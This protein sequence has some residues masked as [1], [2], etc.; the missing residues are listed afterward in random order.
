[1]GQRGDR[2]REILVLV[3]VRATKKMTPAEIRR[4][5]KTLI[6]TQSFYMADE[7]QIRAIAVTS[8]GRTKD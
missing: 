6:N 1:V 3:K 8:P 5:I 2:Q 4:E 7:D